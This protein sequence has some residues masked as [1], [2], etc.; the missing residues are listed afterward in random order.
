MYCAPHF[1]SMIIAKFDLQVKFPYCTEEEMANLEQTVNHAF[2][3]IQTN[4]NLGKAM[5]VYQYTHKKVA[6]LIQWFDQVCQLF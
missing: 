3:D 6:A 1:V 5:E 4:S 2:T